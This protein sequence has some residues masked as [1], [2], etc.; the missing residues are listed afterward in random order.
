MEF[1]AGAMRRLYRLLHPPSGGSGV[2]LSHAF[3][4]ALVMVVFAAL[5]KQTHGPVFHGVELSI[6]GLLSPAAFCTIRGLFPL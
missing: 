4:F 5:S 3:F 6:A 1:Q 2:A